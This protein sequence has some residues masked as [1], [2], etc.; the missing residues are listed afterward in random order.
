MSV[1]GPNLA[2]EL[3][4]TSKEVSFNFSQMVSDGLNLEPHKILRMSFTLRMIIWTKSKPSCLKTQLLLITA[5]HCWSVTWFFSFCLGNDLVPIS[6]IV[7]NEL[8]CRRWWM[9]GEP[10][11]VD[12]IQLGFLWP[13]AQSFSWT[14]MQFTWRTA[15]SNNCLWYSVNHKSLIRTPGQKIQE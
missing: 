13:R 12:S 1:F 9:M 11:K 14:Q 6:W 4:P 8:T 10:N 15:F 5:P 3:W 7:Q 2:G